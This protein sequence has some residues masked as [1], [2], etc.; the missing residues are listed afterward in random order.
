[1]NK[2]YWYAGELNPTDST[3]Q[4]P[5]ALNMPKYRASV[6]VKYSGLA[7]GLAVEL[8]D[9]WSDA[10][11]MYDNYWV[12]NVG[13]R[14]VVDLTVNYRIESLNNLQLTLSVTNLLNNS[15]QEFVGAPYIGR[16]AMLRAAYTLPPF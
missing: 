12:G 5:F 10:F 8:R 2:N 9:R 14:H 16:I 1:M 11:P 7:R 3:S 15:H 13:A 6:G 4:N